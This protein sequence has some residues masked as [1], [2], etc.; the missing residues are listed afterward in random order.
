MEH[1]SLHSDCWSVDKQSFSLQQDHALSVQKYYT[2]N[3]A[4][5]FL[6]LEE[7]DDGIITKL[8]YRNSCIAMTY[9]HLKSSTF[10]FSF[11]LIYYKLWIKFHLQDGIQDI[12][13]GEKGSSRCPCTHLFLWLCGIT[14]LLSSVP[15]TCK[16]C[17]ALLFLSLSIPLHLFYSPAASIR[18]LGGN[19]DIL[20]R[21][22]CLLSRLCSCLTCFILCKK[23][24]VL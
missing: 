16:T 9:L 13:K 18:S 14:C 23:A 11:A 6:S 5:Q 4:F 17:C 21:M 15:M 12:M 22:W 2:H 19:L 8:E 24:D 1:V 10:P 20:F 3:W 7:R